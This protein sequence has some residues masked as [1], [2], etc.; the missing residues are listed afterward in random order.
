MFGMDKKK[1][2]NEGA[3][4]ADP[5]EEAA[6]ENLEAMFGMNKKKVAEPE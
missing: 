1:N 6:I 5:N 2:N 3:K 4:P